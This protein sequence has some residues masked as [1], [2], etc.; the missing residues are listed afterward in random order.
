MHHM[1]PLNA[2]TRPEAEATMQDAAA[3]LRKYSALAEEHF[4]HKLCKSNM[5]AL[6]CR[7][8]TQQMTRG[9][10]V[11]YGEWWVEVM[12]QVTKG[13][14]KYRNTQTPELVVV[15]WLLLRS[16]LARIRVRHPE[17]AR[18]LEHWFP[19]IGAAEM[20]GANLDDSDSHQM[21]GSGHV[22][23]RA[24]QVEGASSALQQFIRNFSPA[25][26]QVN[27]AADARILIYTQAQVLAGLESLI[28][29]ST[30]YKKARSRVSYYVHVQYEETVAGRRD[31]KHYIG[32][33][34][35][36]MLCKPGAGEAGPL[37][38]ATADLYHAQLLHTATGAIWRVANAAVPRL[39]RYSV[40]L[41]HVVGKVAYMGKQ[42]AAAYYM[43]YHMSSTQAS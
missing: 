15:N 38:I 31:K 8:L 19:D 40:A 25:G 9:H 42:G 18:D 4:G 24:D 36:L 39:P 20:R 16:A 27:M 41:D 7:L 3:D 35:S 1:Q 23:R 6:N 17:H 21:L 11:F 10:T 28:F 13:I 22:P 14:V 33:V 43:A 32:E 37:R 30:G 34:K 29:H 2:P 5:H 26:W 12:V